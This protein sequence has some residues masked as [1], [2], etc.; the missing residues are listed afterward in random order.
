MITVGL[1]VGSYLISVRK[2]DMEKLSPYECGFN[3]FQD[4]RQ[5]FEVKFYLVG[6]L[7]ILFDLELSYLFPWVLT[8][9][10]YGEMMIFLAL[11]TVGFI[12][13]WKKGAL[14]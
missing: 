4:S 6:I 7:F 9:E 12:Y 3:P 11:V 2:G 1:I 14:D 10:G 13:E 8:L 5:E